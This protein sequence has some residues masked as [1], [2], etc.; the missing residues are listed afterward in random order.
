MV[1]VEE[2]V[3]GGGGAWWW[4][5]VRGGGVW[6]LGEGGEG[7]PAERV[8]EEDGREDARPVGE[9]PAEEHRV[10]QRRRAIGVPIRVQ[11]PLPGHTSERN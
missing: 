11:Q 3:R 9:V 6:C 1:E 4:C 7:L 2:V 5:V 10:R 8:D